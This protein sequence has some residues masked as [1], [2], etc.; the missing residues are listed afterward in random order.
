MKDATNWWAQQPGW[1]HLLP[2][3]LRETWPWFEAVWAFDYGDPRQLADLILTDA[4]PPEYTAAVAAIVAGER[5]PNRKATAKA[6]IPAK[7]RAE[8]AVLV[9]VCQGARDEVKFR[10]FN[11]CRD[12]DRLNGIGAGAVADSIEPVE[13]MRNADKLGRKCLQTAAGHWGV[14]TETIENLMREAKARLAAWPEV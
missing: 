11:P 12:P 10:A 9:S 8:T 7:E 6:K 3:R 1:A 2:E 5:K 14:S 4:I 13:L